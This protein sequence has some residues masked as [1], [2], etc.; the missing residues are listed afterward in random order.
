MKR[1]IIPSLLIV[2]ILAGIFSPITA[3]LSVRKFLPIQTNTTYAQTPPANPTPTATTPVPDNVSPDAYN[4]ACGVGFFGGSDIGGCLELIFYYIPFTLGNF[5]LGLSATL[6]DTFA[7]LTLSSKMY[8]SSTFITEGWQL[9]RDFAN[10]FFILVL[11]FIALS[12]VLGLEIGHANPKKMLASVVIIALVINF[13]MMI[14]E[15]V[16]DASNSLALVFYNQISVTGANGAPIKLSDNS[17][18][19]DNQTQANL[20]VKPIPIS[21]ALVQAFRPQ[22]LYTASFYNNLLKPGRQVTFTA[23]ASNAAAGA[24][25][26]A[27]LGSFIPGIGTLFGGGIGL[28]GS[29]FSTFFN[30]GQQ[31]V[32]EQLLIGIYLVVG[33]MYL[34]AAYS[35]FIAALSFVGRLISLWV[36]IIFAPIAF[37]TY[38]IPGAR[39]WSGLGWSE[40]WKNLFATAFAAPIYFFF[41]LLISLMAKSTIF[42]ADPTALGN[43]DSMTVLLLTLLGFIF[44]IAMLLKATSYVKKAAGDI[45]EMVFKGAA[46]L[47][48]VGLMAASGSLAIVGSRTIG[49]YYKNKDTD[50]NR[51]LASGDVTEKTK[52]HFLKKYSGKKR[53]EFEAMSPAQL[54]QTAEWQSQQKNAERNLKTIRYMAAASYDPRQNAV[55]NA[56]S[57]TTGMNME[58][59]GAWSTANTAG[60]HEA[61]L[62]RKAKKDQDF[63]ATL[64]HSHDQTNAIDD[65]IAKRKRAI[66]IAEADVRTARATPKIEVKN[67]AKV[68]ALVAAS[69][70]PLT[71]IKA[72]TDALAAA[73]ALPDNIQVDN[74]DIKK[75]VEILN[76][77]S[78]GAGETVT[79]DD[80]GKTAPNSNYKYTK[81]DIGKSKSRYTDADVLAGA[82]KADGSTV[83]K[84]DVLHGVVRTDSM[85]IQQLEKLKDG[86]QN[87]RSNAFFHQQMIQTTY[88]THG[89]KY[90]DLGQVTRLG[91]MDFKK[92][93]KEALK[94]VRGEAKNLVKMWSNVAIAG[95]GALV[96]GVPGAI[97][98]GL[99]SASLFPHDSY[100]SGFKQAVTGLNGLTFQNKNMRESDFFNGRGMS[101]RRTNA[102]AVNLASDTAHKLHEYQSK[103]KSDAGGFLG[104]LKSIVGSGES[105]GGGGGHATPA[106]DSS[107]GHGGGHH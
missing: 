18:T 79:S 50:L 64:G 22:V 10:M 4:K 28:V 76:T 58:G 98:A 11:L 60:G 53:A 74:P 27:V 6:F 92:V 69:A 8:L 30:S 81:N 85:S 42:P 3:S 12:L 46:M 7:A 56:I 96:A 66:E 29:V 94:S 33:A 104:I 82:K 67:T 21:Q 65:T 26:G 5:V 47:G 62:L 103:Y 84:A 40:W 34:V 102:N 1:F 80:E 41:L 105:H 52:E 14:T 15:V 39:T 99:A 75:K 73:N 95:A 23:V 45:G 2:A 20:G 61:F 86:L 57:K 91:H 25:G 24:A 31:T 35:F 87:S 101:A 83:S 19:N 37:V 106:A 17:I 78:K 89:E 16:I 51:A 107:G 49:R 54:H 55:M 70:L 13:S 38:I 77:V 48:G 90:N 72:R 59:F 68:A 93:S 88:H 71:D 97:V 44:L 9:T 100:L 36:A 63:A 43:L 32:P